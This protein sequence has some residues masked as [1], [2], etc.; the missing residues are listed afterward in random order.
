LPQ[1]RARDRRDRAVTAPLPPD[2]PRVLRSKSCISSKM[3][4]QLKTR[5]FC[6]PG[7]WLYEPSIDVDCRG[8]GGEA[9]G[10][11]VG[12][13]VGVARRAV[14]PAAVGPAAA[15]GEEEPPPVLDVALAGG[16]R[17]RRD[18]VAISACCDRSITPSERV[19]QQFTN[20]RA[21]AWR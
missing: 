9:P 4:V 3:P 13:A 21:P 1:V 5:C 11:V 15:T 18:R 6:A 8:P 12:Q 2:T 7:P 10:D 16:D 17:R 14:A 20:A 19:T